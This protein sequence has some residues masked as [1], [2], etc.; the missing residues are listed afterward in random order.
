MIG[1]GG[2]DEERSHEHIS[3]E[4]FDREIR[5]IHERIDLMAQIEQSDIDAITAE[6]ASAET[7]IQGEVTALEQQIANGVPASQLDL[8][9]LKAAAD[10]IAAIPGNVAPS[11]APAP[12]PDPAPAPAPDPAPAVA[13]SL[14]TYGGQ[15]SD[16]DTSA[17]PIAD[18]AVAGTGQSLYTYIGDT[19]PGDQNGNGLDAGLWTLY[20]GNTQP[21]AAA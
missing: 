4:E 1:F 12:V 17:W 19:A 8:S 3:R 11:P 2:M 20:T 5:S 14:Y 7:A 16:I 6:L 9:G 18:V 21:V 13:A 10:G 15:V